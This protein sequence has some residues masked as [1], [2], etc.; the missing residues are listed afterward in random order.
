MEAPVHPY[1]RAL[2]SSIPSLDPGRG[3]TRDLIRG[4]ISDQTPPSGGCVFAPRCQLRQRL[5]NPEAVRNRAARRSS[6]IAPDHGAA[7]HFADQAA[8]EPPPLRPEPG[9]AA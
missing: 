7:C 3:V 4:E 6:V 8:L 5:G 1:T 9:T 2:F